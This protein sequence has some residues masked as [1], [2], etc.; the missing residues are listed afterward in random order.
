MCSDPSTLL[1]EHTDETCEYEENLEDLED[2]QPQVVKSERVKLC[3]CEHTYMSH[4]SM[5]RM[6]RILEVIK[7]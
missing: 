3:N 6:W 5:R 2:Y 7:W 1:C 4:V